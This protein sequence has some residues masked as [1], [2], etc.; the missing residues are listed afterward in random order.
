MIITV[1]IMAMEA[2]FLASKVKHF[3]CILLKL[4]NIMML[5]SIPGVLEM[6]VMEEQYLILEFL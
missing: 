4:I 3:Q 1:V 2:G 6:K 5:H